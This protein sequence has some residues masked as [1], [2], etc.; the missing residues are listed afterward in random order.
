VPTLLEKIKENARA[1]L[2]LPPNRPPVV[3]LAKFKNFLKVESHR[4]KILHRGGGEG[5]HIC[6]GRAT[7]VDQLMLYLFEAIKASN[8]ILT[9]KPLPPLALV[10]IGGYG[11]RELNPHSDIDIMFL[12][13]GDVSPRGRHRE[14]MS[15]LV[16]GMLLTLYDVGLKVG[17][18]VRSVTDCVVVANGDMQSKTS[19]IEARLI[20]GDEPLFQKMEFVVEEK[21]VKDQADEYIAARLKDQAERRAKYGDSACMLEPNIKNGCGGLRDYQNLLWMAHFKYHVHSLEE[22]EKREWITELERTQLDAAYGFLLRARNE[23]H[24]HTGR[25]VDVLLKAVQPSVATNLG[26]G[27]RSPVKRIEK[28]MREIYTHMR[29]VYLITRTLEARLAFQQKPKPR[30]SLRDFFRPRPLPVVEMVDGFQIADGELR[31][32]S[33]RVF[34][35]QPRRLMRAFLHVQQR[36]LALN[37]DLAQMIRRQLDLADGDFA[38]DT[39]V[40]ETFL[41]ILSQRGN[42]APILRAMHEVGLLGRFM[43]EFGLLTC[44]VQ[45]EFFHRYTADE[46]TLVCVEMLDA[47]WAAQKAPFNRYTEILQKVER[48]FVLYLALLVHD[49]GKARHSR[50]HT[51]DSTR[52]ALRAAK[53]LQLDA[54]ATNSLKLLVENHLALIQISQKR[55]LED[56]LVARRFA[57]EIQTV[58]NLNMLLL[59]TFADTLGTRSDLWTDF[60]ESLVWTL[61]EKT[62]QE[63]QG[64]AVAG[65]RT[66]EKH[67]DSLAQAT[68]NLLNKPF[69]EEE[70]KAHFSTMPTGYF[71]VNAAADIWV[72]LQLAHQFMQFQVAEGDHALDPAV[73]WGNV[74]DRG[75]ATVRICTWDRPGLFSQIAASLTAADL[76]ILSARIFSRPDGVIFDSFQVRDTKSGTMPGREAREKFESVLT[77]VLTGPFDRAA[78][79]IARQKA[80][81]PLRYPDDEP[82]PTTIHF[83]NGASEAFTI[84]DVTTAD[85]PGLLYTLSRTLS[86]VHLDIASSKISTEMGV[87][88][89]SFYARAIAGGKITDPAT[90]AAVEKRLQTAIQKLDVAG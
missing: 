34:H 19:L 1:R 69:P 31:A 85:R 21:C 46:H 4:L 55:D 14:S 37:P 26:Y 78:F 3:E 20:L 79:L 90:L 23:L 70:F 39:H 66:E 88:F 33:P 5:R 12:H 83:D 28:F 44:L 22:L 74:P 76:N 9:Q 51:V 48:P 16:E 60:K 64:K 18:S 53:R 11:R 47:I 81:R 36:R 80:A 89:D 8:P 87:A 41:E 68:L 15:A 17:H 86:E 65:G 75:Y 57:K 52:Y 50:A 2:A 35:D 67:K 7:V 6:H 42:V 10:A 82:L 30:R 59:H 54:P 45:H 58:D 40:R 77:E 13:N 38:K 84:I 29:H 62:K 32:I 71:Q 61:Y 27:D 63:L 49:S 24:Y 72:D 56:P 25:S 73:A 43:P